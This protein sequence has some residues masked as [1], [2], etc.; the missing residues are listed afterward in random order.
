MALKFIPNTYAFRWFADNRPEP[1]AA[2]GLANTDVA[3]TLATNDNIL[4]LR[5]MIYNSG[6]TGSTA[7]L[8]AQYSTDGSTFVAMGS[9]NHWN[10]ANGQAVDGNTCAGPTFFVYGATFG[11]YH[12]S[13][14]IS[15][16]WVVGTR[17]EFDFALQATATV[18]GSQLYTFR[19]LIAGV[20]ITPT[21][22]KANPTLI[23]AATASS[24]IHFMPII[25]TPV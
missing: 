23:T 9:S 10:Y 8:T 14:S 13:A 5:A 16:T 7:V 17:L 1:I 2:D 18:L 21:V 4:R 6:T 25:S 20:A 3:P 24:M 11:K 22:G 12:E 15:E 19:F